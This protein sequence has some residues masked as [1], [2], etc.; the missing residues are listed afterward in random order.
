MA[1][2]RLYADPVIRINDVDIDTSDIQA[3]I[4]NSTGQ[5]IEIIKNPGISDGSRDI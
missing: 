3:I 1:F 5:I 4:V 2:V